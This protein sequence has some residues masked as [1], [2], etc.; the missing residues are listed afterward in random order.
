MFS[1]K[2]VAF[3]AGNEKLAAICIS[4]TVGLKQ[5]NKEIKNEMPLNYKSIKN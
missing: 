3:C 4:P 1:I 2:K 5:Y